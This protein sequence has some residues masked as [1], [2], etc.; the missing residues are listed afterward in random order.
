MWL[1]RAVSV[2]ALMVVAVFAGTSPG[3][4][5]TDPYEILSR[6]FETSGGLERLRAERTEYFEGDLSVGAMWGP[7]KIWIQKPDLNRA[8]IQ[9]G[10]ISVTEGDNGEI[11]WMLDT[12]GKLQKI[13]K[14]DEATLKRKEVD[15]RMAEYEYADRGSDIF[16][17]TFEGTEKVEETDCYVVK[18]SNNINVDR[19]TYYISVDG[20]H[21]EK[22]VDIQGENSADSYYGD[23]REVDGIL[24]AFYIKRI[25]HQTGQAQEITVTRYDSNPD[26]DPVLFDPPEEAGKD[27]E[28]TAGA[29]AENIP[30]E[31]IGHHLFIPVAVNGVERL[32]ILDTGAGMSVIDQAF[33]DEMGLKPEGDLK[34]QGAA[35]TVDVAFATLPPYEL[36]GI[37]FKEQTVAVIEMSELIRRLGIDIAGILGFDFLSRFVTKV[38]YANELV[39]FYDPEAFNYTGDGRVLDA[40]IKESVF[41]TSATLDGNHSGTWLFDLGA[42][43]TH[44]DGCYALREGYT[45][46]HGVLRMGHGAGNEYQLKAV[47]G[48]S[49]LFA[50]FTLY[51]PYISFAYGGTDTVF[52]ADRIG[53]LGNTLFRNFVVY[54]DYANE[55][56]ILE[57]GERFNQPWPEDGSGLNIAWTVDRDGV[58][59]IYVSPETPA[60]KAGFEKG[61][62]ITSINNTPVE[63]EDGV[64]AVRELLTEEPGTVHEVMVQREGGEKTIRLTLAELY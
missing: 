30:F 39:S 4:E 5:M 24:K 14:A 55:H 60:E 58:E 51:E 20:F 19:H 40:H 47:K 3:Q 11:K 32:W 34:G 16:A 31:F 61:D 6:Y 13:T 35:G 45:N 59:V 8:E 46:K 29:A 38:D 9:I 21:L 27:Y 25:P 53:I 64:I 37:S 18:V 23:Y 28:F 12:N 15:R 33:A 2:A 17:V 26:I 22:T 1:W 10:P 7:I 62:I 57:K 54:V 52:T 43:M 36:M 44:L 56:V 63:P 42:G 50:G 49:L 41:E 48:D